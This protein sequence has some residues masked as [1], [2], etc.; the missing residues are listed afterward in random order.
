MVNDNFVHY[1]EQSE[2]IFSFKPYQNDY[3]S[4]KDTGDKDKKTRN[5]DLK[6]AWSHD[7][8]VR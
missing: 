5:I 1:L 3:N 7:L 2:E 6:P 4:V 8:Q